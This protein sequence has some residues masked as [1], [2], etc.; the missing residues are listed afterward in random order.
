M[1]PK[2]DS[3]DKE[4]IVKIALSSFCV[5]F[6][7]SK[8]EV[9]GKPLLANRSIRFRRSHR[10]ASSHWRLSSTLYYSLVV[11]ESSK[12]NGGRAANFLN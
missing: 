9:L 2:I 8:N 7:E 10:I 3:I 5:Q 12:V 4:V 6:Q 11:S 1:K